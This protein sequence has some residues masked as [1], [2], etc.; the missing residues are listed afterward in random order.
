M[1]WSAPRSVRRATPLHI[2]RSKST[3]CSLLEVVGASWGQGGKSY[4]RRPRPPLES[5]RA[6]DALVRTALRQACY[7][8][9]HHA[10]EKHMLQ[11]AGGRRGVVGA[12][13]EK[14]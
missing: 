12:R 11:L 13:R 3:C 4:R 10:R 5:P 8:A 2:M 9:A 1:L 6:G 7:T 14:L